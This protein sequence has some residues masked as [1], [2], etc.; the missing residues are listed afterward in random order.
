MKIFTTVIVLT[1]FVTPLAAQWLQHRTPGI[2]RLANGKPDLTAPPPRSADGKPDLTGVWMHEI[3]TVAEVRRLFGKRFD[4]AIQTNSIGMEI[5]TQHKYNFDILVDFKPGE[6]PL[7]PE[8]KLLRPRN[9]DPAR[10]CT[11][12]VGIPAAG[13]RTAARTAASDPAAR[14]PA[15]AGPLVWHR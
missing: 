10:L 3:T 2:P 9:T 4:D 11:G 7:R 15:R 14:L 5:G 12:I 1:A 8:V 6:S 13:G